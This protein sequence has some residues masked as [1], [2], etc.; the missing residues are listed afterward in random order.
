M[1]KLTALLMA[2][3][4][5]SALN[6]EHAAQPNLAHEI[7][8]LKKQVEA[9]N[10]RISE[11][12]TQVSTPAA[13]AQTASFGDGYLGVPGTNSGIGFIISPRLDASYDAGTHA[14]DALTLS[15]LPLDKYEPNA[16]HAGQTNFHGRLSTFGFK[17]ISRTSRGDV[18]TLVD[19][20]F[21]N[22]TDSSYAP[23]LRNAYV[24]FA[25]F[26]VG[27]TT[28]TFTDLDACGR[29]VDAAGI[30]GGNTRQPL[31]RYTQG[32]TKELS[33]VVAAERPYTDYTYSN[34]TASATETSLKQEKSASGSS[35]S[36]R[37]TYGTASMPDFVAGLK[38][39]DGWGYV[40]V[41]GLVRQLSIKKYN[42]DTTAQH[43]SRKKTA[44]AFGVSGAVNVMSNAKVFA[45]VNTGQGLG[46]YI[47]DM[48]GQSAF[49]NLDTDSDNYGKF[50]LVSATHYV[51]GLQI[52]L[53][54]G[55]QANLAASRLDVTVPRSVPDLSGVTPQPA[56]T[57][58]GSRFNKKLTR[59]F[60]NVI[61]SPNKNV[62]MGLEYGYGV[63][64]TSDLRKGKAHRISF[65][66]AYKF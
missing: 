41:R 18:K 53:C 16:A 40:G 23:R 4:V 8:A 7:A 30:L 66:T 6:A 10:V 5:V 43:I 39:A 20:D 45:Q 50:D 1:K 14:G 57:D 47:P 46:R 55:W 26:T 36:T 32:I 52:T 9:Q 58:V 59:F 28:S 3:G 61:Y 62:D 44:T 17:T 49:A 34:S 54:E 22:A 11:L 51:A 33:M 12:S 19:L 13:S 48:G 15:N 35:S 25:G 31:V 21:F 56:S 64:E 29:Q 65:M 2:T 63:R 27:Q 42:V 24:D 60:G 38:Y 37:G